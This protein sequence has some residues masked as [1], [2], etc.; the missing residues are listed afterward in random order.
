MKISRDKKVFITG[1]GGM[2]GKAVYE[3]FS[4][5]C[6]VLATDIDVNEPW[7]EYGDVIDFQEILEKASKFK[8]DLV[9]NLAALTDLEYC[10]KNPEITWKTNALGA[11]NMA[12]ISKKLNATHIYISTAGIF[13]GKQEY[14][15]DFEQPNP[16]SIYAKS[17]YYGEMVV[18]KMLDSYF[19]FRAGWM[20][21]GG[22]KKDKKFI[23]KIFKQILDGKKELFVIND[24]LGTPTYTV[25]FAESMFEIVQTELFGLYNMVCEGSCSRYEIATEFIKLLGLEKEINIKIVDSGFFQSVYFAP[26]PYSE[27]LLNLKLSVRGIN[28]MKDWKECLSDYVESFK[29]HL[30]KGG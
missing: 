6:Q 9:I 12:L 1:C 15:N 10:E 28:Y 16:I 29:P 7:L 18:E 26:R 4:P 23:N 27:K 20:M 25:N 19:I 2:L 24:K 11:E 5:H 22:I 8:P 3:R 30:E 21:G 13:D 14:Y 17:K